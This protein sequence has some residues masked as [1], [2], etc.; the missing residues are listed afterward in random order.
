MIITIYYSSIKLLIETP[1]SGGI[2]TTSYISS[3]HLYKYITPLDNFV[4]AC[5]VSSLSLTLCVCVCVFMCVFE[6]R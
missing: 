6:D 5:E 4:L 1:A 2:S 3:A